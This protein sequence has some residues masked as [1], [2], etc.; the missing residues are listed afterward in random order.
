M[1]AGAPDIPY[2]SVPT[3]WRGQTVA[4]LAGGKSLT[5]AHV[6]HVRGK[7]R[8]IAINRAFQRAPWAD[9]LWATDVD[10][11]WTWHPEAADFPGVMICVRKANDA[12]REYWRQ[13]A[14]VAGHGAMV[15]RHSGLNYPTVPRHEGVSAD[16]RLV[17][18]NNALFQIMSIIA[19]TGV[20]TV[21]LLGADMRGGHWHGG[22]R[23]YGEP[24]YAGSVI[25]PFETLIAP[26]AKANVVVLNA[27]PGSALS[28]R[29]WPHVRLEDVI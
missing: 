13:L 15:L 27:S 19:H 5:E 20:S 28:P 1:R 22:Y 3:C 6:E 4:I 11:F 8:V 23:G 7:C 2:W 24:D 21:L 12:S 25:P 18:G 26:L 9:W 29:W 14:K 16:P 17:R 10:R